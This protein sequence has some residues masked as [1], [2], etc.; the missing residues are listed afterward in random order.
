MDALVLYLQR[1]TPDFLQGIVTTLYLTAVALS[2]GLLL[3]LPTALA[4]VYG[5]R[6]LRNLAIAYIEV[7]RGTPLLVQLFVVYYGLPEIGALFGLQGM[8]ITLDRL[9][10]AFLTLGLNSGAYQAEYFRGALQAVGSGQMTAARALGMTKGQSIL[11]IIL[12]QAL[13][14]ALPA[15]SNEAIS[16]IKYTAVVFLIAVPDIMG[17][18]KILAG[19]YFNPIEIYITVAL[20]YLVL[21][22]IASWLVH[23]LE[24]RLELPGGQFETARH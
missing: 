5:P 9:P 3:G 7:F 20:I 11:H 22:A 23:S 8:G 16:M 1:V 13:R 17:K 15:W 19:R 6:W 21:V 24:R 4:R 14:L 12:P 10:A 2:L 18:A